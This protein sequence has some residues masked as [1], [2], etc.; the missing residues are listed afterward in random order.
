MFFQKDAKK[1]EKSRMF[2]DA[3]EALTS[4]V[5]K[6]IQEMLPRINEDMDKLDLSGDERKEYV[7]NIR[8]KLQIQAYE[9]FKTEMQ[10]IAKE[11][12]ERRGSQIV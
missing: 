6:L 8:S 2:M 10:Q 9:L 3:S 7:E 5:D 11:K 1:I 12:Q 4:S